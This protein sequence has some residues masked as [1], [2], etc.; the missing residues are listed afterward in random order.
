MQTEQETALG[1]YAP[2]ML[3]HAPAGMALF[4][5]HE[6]RLLAANTRYQALLEPQW[7]HGHALGHPLIEFLP[8]AIYTEIAALFRGVVETGASSR[9]E[10]YAASARLGEARYWDWSL[11][12]IAEQGQVRYVLLT[13]AEVT[14]QVQAQKSAEQAK[15][16]LAQ[17]QQELE[18]EQQR[19]EH[20]ETI[21]LSVRSIAEP[22]AFAQALLCAIDTCFSP[23]LLALYSTR[24]EQETLSLLASH[25]PECLPQETPVLPAF[26]A[27]TSGGSLLEAMQQRTPLIRRTSQERETGQEGSSERDTLLALPEVAC[28]V[29]LP[30]WRAQGARCEGVLVA[31]F[32]TEEELDALVVPTLSACA[33]HLTEALAE[34]WM[35]AALADERQRLRTVLDQLPEGVILVEAQSGKVSYANPAAAG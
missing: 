20:L 6:L 2:L 5:A 27:G 23:H 9:M 28:V 12:P 3:E 22:Q 17:V 35:H 14:L 11:E 1:A 7:Q 33:P 21:L 24:S 4:D 19:H 13:I 25:T 30:L 31:G 32:A 15:T 10:A 18:L 26:L 8:R 34:T 16:D 29:Y